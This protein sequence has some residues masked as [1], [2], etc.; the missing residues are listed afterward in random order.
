MPMPMVGLMNT[1]RNRIDSSGAIS[2]EEECEG[3]AMTVVRRWCDAW[4]AR[5]R[6]DVVVRERDAR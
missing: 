5:A 4:N 3:N 1:N 2:R 6:G